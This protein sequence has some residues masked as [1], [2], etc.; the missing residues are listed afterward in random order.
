[1]FVLMDAILVW[2]GAVFARSLAFIARRPI[3]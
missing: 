3:A 1:V 2:A